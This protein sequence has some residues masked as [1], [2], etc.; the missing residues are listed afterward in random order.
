MILRGPHGKSLAGMGR[1]VRRVFLAHL[2][3]ELLV[4]KIEQQMVVDLALVSAERGGVA[5]RQPTH[6]AFYRK[7]RFQTDYFFPAAG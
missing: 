5:A 7:I 2:A 4:P 1:Q 3:Q 6:A